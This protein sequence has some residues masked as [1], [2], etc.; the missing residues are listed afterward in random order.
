MLS[1]AQVEAVLPVVR[2]AV[3]PTPQFAWPLLKARIGAEVF[4]K[5]EN[6]TPT[7]SFKVRGGLV[8]VDRLKRER[9][10]IRGIVSAT[11]GNHGQS[12]AFAGSRAGV[13]VTI[14]VPMGNSTEKNAAMRALGAELIEHGRDFD[15]ARRRALELASA[16]GLEYAP[17]FHPDLVAGVATY[18]YE[19]FMALSDLDT[20]Y[21]PIG[22]GSG[23]CGVIA[24][25]DA[26]GLSTRVVGVVSDRANAY[27]RS[28]DAGRVVQ[29]D[30]ALTF[31]DGMA[32]RVPDPE[33]LEAIRRGAE[34]IVEVSDDEVAEAIRILFSDTH[35]TAEGA[36]AAP[37]AALIKER[38]RQ[39]CRRVAVIVTGQNIDRP[40]MQTVL[41]GGTPHID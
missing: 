39:Q 6:H 34:H 19:L 25:R 11:R 1:L 23:I 13:A 35:A 16:R 7:G 33:A 38:A 32:V 3:P 18:A 15:E 8:Y 4:V 17:S 24:V 36:G 28:V 20:V 29:T 10:H 30:S 9:P 26:L 5:H 40:W 14:V 12:L 2:A 21:V 27:R 41:A 31:A 37:L 22:L